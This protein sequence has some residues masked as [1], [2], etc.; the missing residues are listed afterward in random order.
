MKRICEIQSCLEE[1]SIRIFSRLPGARLRVRVRYG[2]AI[3][4]RLS[5]EGEKHNPLRIGKDEDE[6]DIAALKIIRHRALRAS[7]KRV[8]GENRVHVV[9]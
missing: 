8:D 6:L 4:L 3:S 9:V 1:L 7:F 5:W 2:E